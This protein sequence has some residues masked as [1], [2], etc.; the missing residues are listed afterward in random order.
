MRPSPGRVVAQKLSM[1][2]AQDT[3]TNLLSTANIGH[4]TNVTSGQHMEQSC[5]HLVGPTLS[6]GELLCRN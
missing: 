5:Q 1:S 4:R 6:T 2:P 3:A